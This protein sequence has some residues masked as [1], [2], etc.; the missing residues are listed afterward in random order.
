MSETTQPDPQ[1][2]AS[3]REY[4]RT[5]WLAIWSATLPTIGTTE[6]DE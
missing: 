5:H 6:E 1:V 4:W 2:A 3:M